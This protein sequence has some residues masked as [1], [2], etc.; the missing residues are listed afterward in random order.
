[1]ISPIM[2]TLMPVAVMAR[3]AVPAGRDGNGSE[4]HSGG[5]CRS[6]DAH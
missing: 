2:S 6:F 5:K 4:G 1:M 3:M